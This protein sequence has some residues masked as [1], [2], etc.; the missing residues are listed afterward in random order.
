MEQS[1]IQAYRLMAELAIINNSPDTLERAK[2]WQ[3]W[4]ERAKAWADSLSQP[5]THPLLR[6]VQSAPRPLPQNHAGTNPQALKN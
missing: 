6:L 2:D 1:Y 3:A 4:N 5:E